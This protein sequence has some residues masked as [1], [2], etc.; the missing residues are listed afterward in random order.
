ME[1]QVAAQRLRIRDA[2]DDLQRAS[3]DSIAAAAAIMSWHPPVAPPPSG[4]SGG[5]G[6]GLVRSYGYCS[7][8]AAGVVLAMAQQ[9]QPGARPG[10]EAPGA[11]FVGPFRWGGG[12]CMGQ[13]AG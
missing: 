1:E 13:Y 6:G 7:L 9:V 11:T 2:E 10:P 5:G 12:G 3:E 4:G 8:M